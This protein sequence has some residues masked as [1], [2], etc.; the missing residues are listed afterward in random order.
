MNYFSIPGIKPQSEKIDFMNRLTEYVC[1][2][3][4]VEPAMVRSKSRKREHSEPRQV[5]MMLIKR[6]KK[7]T[8]S[9]V[10]DY[11]GKRDHASII[12]AANRI[13]DLMETEKELKQIVEKVRDKFELN[14]GR[15]K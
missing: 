3:Y 11:Y 14:Y 8:D 15:Y 10:G 7:I 5:C 9:Q 6:H 2:F 1:T 4:G 12:A 13:E